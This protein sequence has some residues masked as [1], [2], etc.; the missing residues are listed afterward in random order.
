MSVISR[1]G[2]FIFLLLLGLVFAGLVTSEWY[3]RFAR[4]H[5]EMQLF[6]LPT[7]KVSHRITSSPTFTTNA[8]PA[9]CGGDLTAL[10][11]LSSA[12]TSYQECREPGLRIKDPSGY[13]NR[14]YDQGLTPDAVV[15]GDS[16]MATGLLDDMFASQLA[17]Q[18]GLFIYNQAMIGHGPIISVERYFSDP[19]HQKQRPA[20]LIWGFAER[21]IGGTFFERLFFFITQGKTLSRED[22]KKSKY[23]QHSKVHWDSFTPEKLKQSLPAS[24]LLA[25]S[26]QW[27]WNRAR[28][29]IFGLIHPDLIPARDLVLDGPMLFYKH[30]VDSISV[31]EETRQIPSVIQAI[32]AF[33]AICEKQDTQLIV[34]LIPEKEQ[35]Y[36]DWL[37]TRFNSPDNPL[38]PSSL[39]TIETELQKQD[40][41]VVNML[42][43]FNEA[44]KQGKRVYWRDDTHW[45]PDGAGFAA[46]KVWEMMKQR[47]L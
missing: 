22:F 14:N 33:D 16:F 38:P 8:I 19:R 30:H 25:Q 45:N 37:P 41:L 23:F 17:K 40:V 47:L 9:R 39:G 5:F 31:P 26:A 6:H 44:T 32:K 13:I 35:V 20:F 12:S 15:V 34:V 4:Y 42:P 27:I 36:R 43:V 11:G 1:K 2:S 18:S 7:R 3:F 29:L 24:S 28:Y 21:E 10:I 46:Q